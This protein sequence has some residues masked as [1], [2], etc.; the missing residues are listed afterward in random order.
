MVPS[1]FLTQ[2]IKLHNFISSEGMQSPVMEGFP[3][4]ITQY[5]KRSDLEK[6]FSDIVGFTNSEDI[7]DDD[8]SK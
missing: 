4:D 5:A 2:D 6:L 8:E 3:I 1:R 7:S